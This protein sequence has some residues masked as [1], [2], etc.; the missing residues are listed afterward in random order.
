VGERDNVRAAVE[1][2]TPAFPQFFSERSVRVPREQKS[3]ENREAGVNPARSRHCKERVSAA[4]S[5]ACC[6]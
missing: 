4:L 5:R 6:L 1:K 2:G 3:G